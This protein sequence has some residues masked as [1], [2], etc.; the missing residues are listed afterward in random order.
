LMVPTTWFCLEQI[1]VRAFDSDERLVG[2][3]FLDV[4]VYVTSLRTLKNLLLV[5][6]AVKSVWLVAFQAS[7]RLPRPELSWTYHSLRIGRPVQTSSPCEG[8]EPSLRNL[9]RFFLR[10][11]GTSDSHRRR[12]RDPQ[13]I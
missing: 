9:C 11:R 7:S 1:F 6:D 5:G 2:V 4:G 3:A 8:Y 13:D 12:G 10:Q